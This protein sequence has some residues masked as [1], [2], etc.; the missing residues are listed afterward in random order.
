MRAHKRKRIED[1]EKL[2]SLNE[3]SAA[4][5]MYENDLEKKQE[6]AAEVIATMHSHVID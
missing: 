1:A 6:I 3:K 2:K 5:V 4:A